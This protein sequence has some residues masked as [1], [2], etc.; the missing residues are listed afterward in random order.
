LFSCLVDAA[1]AASSTGTY[2]PDGSV[3]RAEEIVATIRR[4]A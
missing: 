2:G 1:Q 4:S 3:R